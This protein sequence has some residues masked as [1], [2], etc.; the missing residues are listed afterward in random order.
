MWWKLIT[1]E[2]LTEWET[3]AFLNVQS[4]KLW[5]HWTLIPSKSL[6]LSK[7][8][9]SE[10]C[11]RLCICFCP[12]HRISTQ[13][14]CRWEMDP[15]SPEGSSTI[16]HTVKA[17]RKRAKIKGG[18]AKKISKIQTILKWINHSD[19]RIKRE[20]P[21]LYDWDLP[22]Y[23]KSSM[24]IRCQEGKA[25]KFNA[26]AHCSTPDRYFI[27]DIR[28]HN[29]RIV[30]KEVWDE[31][32]MN[33]FAKVSAMRFGT[34]KMHSPAHESA[35]R[36]NEQSSTW[37]CLPV[38]NIRL[39]VNLASSL[40]CPLLRHEDEA[41]LTEWPG[42]PSIIYP[43]TFNHV[44]MSQQQPRTL[45]KMIFVQACS[46]HCTKRISVSYSEHQSSTG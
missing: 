12:H 45:S 7:C 34:P 2:E 3:S 9:P 27:V 8:D 20:V 25:R 15:P 24:Q 13:L 44:F 17:W 46:L 4:D 5:T 11:S 21:A 6:F 16:F 33:S 14:N 28:Q 39:H 43:Y 18:I 22:C 40:E 26:P 37:N 38:S 29:A 23:R 32:S 42:K 10:S 35:E 19:K 1:H 36:L 41:Q 31:R 30:G